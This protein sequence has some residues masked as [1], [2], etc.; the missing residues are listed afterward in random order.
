MAWSDILSHQNLVQRFQKSLQRKRMANTYLFVG[1]EG[2]GKRTFA[3]KLAQAL[4]CEINPEQDLNPCGNCGGCQQVAAGTHPDLIQVRKPD[5][6]AFIP[7]ELFIGDKEHRH[8]E[9]LCHDIG[10]KPFR[11]GRKIAI[12]DDSDFLNV[13]GAN[14]LLKTLEEPPARSVLILIGTSEKRQL[15]TIVSRSQVI[16]FLP[17]DSNQ[18]L[19]VLQTIQSSQPERFE[20]APPLEVLAEESGGSVAMAIRL[21]EP[22]FLDFKDRLFEKL[23]S[24]DPADDFAGEVTDFVDAAGKEAS[25][26]RTR[27]SHVGD[28]AIEFYRHLFCTLSGATEIPESQ[29]KILIKHIPRAC[30][31]FS[32]T[33]LA[34]AELAARCIDRTLTFQKQVFANVGQALAVEAWLLDLGFICRGE[35]LV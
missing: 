30:N 24:L 35:Q 23:A 5:D 21:A 8:R 4:L 12:I 19:Q 1:Q 29:S 22:G 18:V 26:K 15:K 28:F 13:E 20:D 9:G 32:D 27:L 10:L 31:Q 11:G 25:K 14:C 34:S 6:K 17:L 33:P 7:I 2:I 3:T 16:R